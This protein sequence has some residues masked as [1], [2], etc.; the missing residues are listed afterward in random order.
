MSLFASIVICMT[1]IRLSFDKN[2]LITVLTLITVL[3][4]LATYEK[5]KDRIGTHSVKMT[6]TRLKGR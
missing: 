3:F 4:K 5:D 1:V 2:K 6:E